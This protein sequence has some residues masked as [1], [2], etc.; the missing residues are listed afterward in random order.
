MGCTQHNGWKIHI[1]SITA[2]QLLYL[3]NGQQLSSIIIPNWDKTKTEN[4]EMTH[5][6]ITQ[7]HA[8]TYLLMSSSAGQYSKQLAHDI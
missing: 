8:H 1:S 7:D 3:Q 4:K 6:A 2:G 5:E